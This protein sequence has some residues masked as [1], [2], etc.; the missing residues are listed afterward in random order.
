MI[1]EFTLPALVAACLLVGC[2][3][4]APETG[5]APTPDAATTATQ[6]AKDS[7]TMAMDSTSMKT[8]STTMMS[9]S[10]MSTDS[11]MAMPAD[12]TAK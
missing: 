11:T 5:A 7:T 10:T 3:K 6:P 8:D 2:N 1:R 4:N 12:S 9:D